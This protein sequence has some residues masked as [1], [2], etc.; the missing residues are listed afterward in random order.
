MISHISD[1]QLHDEASVA[2]PSWRYCVKPGATVRVR[3]GLKNCDRRSKPVSHSKSSTCQRILTHSDAL[4]H[5]TVVAYSTDQ[6]SEIKMSS[7]F[8]RPSHYRVYRSAV[9]KCNT[10]FV[11]IQ[12]HISLHKGV[13]CFQKWPLRRGDRR[14][15]VGN[16]SRMKE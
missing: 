16:Y 12:R 15:A 11:T 13:S 5:Y 14:E 9:K 8:E 3:R 4:A 1:E 7:S 6:A 2:S 10:Y